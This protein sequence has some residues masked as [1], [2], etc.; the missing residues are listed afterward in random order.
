MT[1]ILRSTL[2]ICALMVVAGA[3]VA[4]EPGIKSLTKSHEGYSHIKQ[5]ALDWSYRSDSH[6]TE[7]GRQSLLFAIT[8]IVDIGPER[9]AWQ[10]VELPPLAERYT[11]LEDLLEKVTNVCTPFLCPP[12]PDPPKPVPPPLY[13]INIIPAVDVESVFGLTVQFNEKKWLWPRRTGGKAVLSTKK[14]S[15]IH[16]VLAQGKARCLSP[17]K[18][19]RAN[20]PVRVIRFDS[21]FHYFG[22]AA[23]K[24]IAKYWNRLNK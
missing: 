17:G 12:D 9:R 10:P 21:K 1:Q 16:L 4:Q 7:S 20:L 8:G 13:E 3:G 18:S 14:T 11:I 23:C 6:L 15:S 2:T 22:T 19:M 5:D 24:S